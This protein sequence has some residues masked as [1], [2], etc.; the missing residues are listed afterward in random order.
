MSSRSAF[1]SRLSAL[2]QRV[3]PPPPV[4]VPSAV[5]LMTTAGCA[6]DPW[7]VAVLESTSSRILL[8][9]SRQAGK[10]LVSAALALS[11]A[12]Q[13]RGSLV[14][15]LAPSLRQS[16]ESFRAVLTLY[17]PWAGQ[18]PSDAESALRLELTNG[19][20]VV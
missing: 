10:T 5:E 6:P 18:M 4:V 11:T 7:Q 8:N 17:R 20:R 15:M 19:S 16:M 3:L 2:E 1:L 9:C 13:E 14:L 12:M